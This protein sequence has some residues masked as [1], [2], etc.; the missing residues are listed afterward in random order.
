MEIQRGHSAEAFPWASP[1]SALQQRAR[2]AGLGILS[3]RFR[4][5]LPS[6]RMCPVIPNNSQ[7]KVLACLF[8]LLFLDAEW[9]GKK[10][11]QWNKKWWVHKSHSHGMC[12][13]WWW[14]SAF[15]PQPQQNWRTP[16]PGCPRSAPSRGRTSTPSARPRSSIWRYWRRRT[17]SE[18]AGTYKISFQPSTVQVE[19]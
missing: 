17:W 1:S 10:Y 14:L 2:A 8:S 5:C 7:N 6:N 4:R 16:Q 13:R 3:L 15:G 9:T 19:K 18:H 12:V 11:I